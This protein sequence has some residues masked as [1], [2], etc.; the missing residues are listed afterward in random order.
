MYKNNVLAVSLMVILSSSAVSAQINSPKNKNY[1][2]NPALE[3]QGQS[4]NQP[5]L[6][7]TFEWMKG[8]LENHP[9]KTVWVGESASGNHNETLTYDQFRMVENCRFAIHEI[10][11]DDGWE[12]PY[13]MVS[14]VFKL[15][16]FDPNSIKILSA[17]E[18]SSGVSVKFVPDYWLLRVDG[19]TFYD[20]R[21]GVSFDEARNS[22]PERGN[23]NFMDFHIADIDL[24]NRAAEALRHL[25]NLCGGKS[26]T[27]SNN[28]EPF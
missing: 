19:P 12:K 25:I 16:D 1:K 3:E 14:H 4:N 5:S 24:A 2:T 17:S 13:T 7:E 11:Y 27:Q 6:E 15:A 18:L 22:T 20:I 8:K 28:K 26:S 10:H 21:N 23:Q 9:I